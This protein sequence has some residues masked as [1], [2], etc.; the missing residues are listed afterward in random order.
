NIYPVPAR[1]SRRITMTIHEQLV[2]QKDR[3]YYK[4]AFNR[5]DTAQQ[6]DLKVSTSGCSAPRTGNGMLQGQNFRL[7]IDGILTLNKKSNKQDLN[8]AIAFSLEATSNVYCVQQQEGKTFF[9]ARVSHQVPVLLPIQ[10]KKLLVY[11]DASGSAAKRNLAREISFLKQYMQR[12]QTEILTLVTFAETL[13]SSRIFYP[14][15]NK[16]WMDLL[17]QLR[18]DGATRM[19]QLNLGNNEHDVVMVFS[20]G[21]HSFGAA[22]P[23]Q[24]YKPLYTISTSLHRDTIF[25]KNL[26]GNSGGRYIDLTKFSVPEAIVHSSS[27]VNKLMDIQS[28]AG[29]TLYEMSSEKNGFILR[30]TL[31]SDDTLTFIY[32]NRQKE[33]SRELMVLKKNGGCTARGIDRL[34]ML[35]QLQQR[36]LYWEDLLEFGL[37]QKIVTQNTAYIVLERIEDYIKYKITPPQEL[38]AACAEQ[39][40]ITQSPRSRRQMLRERDISTIMKDV[41]K[42]YNNQ[43]YLYDYTINGLTFYDPR[44]FQTNNTQREVTELNTEPAA[45]LLIGDVVNNSMNEVVVTGAFGTRRR[46]M[47]NSATGFYDHDYFMGS[48]DV[49]HILSGWVPGVSITGPNAAPGATANITIRG[50]G[51]L[52]GSSQPL[53]VLNGIPLD[54][55]INDMISVNDIESITVLKDAAA[56][57][58]YGSRGVN[59]VI[60]ITS[61]K[62]RPSSQY[63]YS[64]SYRLKDM[65]D[66][67]YLVRLKETGMNHKWAV[68]QEMRMYYGDHPI[69]YLEAAQ[70]FFEN[71]LTSQAVNIIMNAAEVS[72]GDHTVLRAIGYCMESW[73]LFAKASGIYR[74]LL[75]S[76]P[77]NLNNYHD[78]AWSLYQ[79]GKVEE[80]VRLLYTAIPLNLESNEHYFVDTKS[81]LL[82]DLNAM[83]AMHK[84]KYNFSFI[85]Q[86]LL[87]P[88][89]VELRIVITSNNSVSIYPE[90]REP[91]GS[92]CTGYYTKTQT[93]GYIGGDSH[94]GN[95]VDYNI[96]KA[97]K[98]KY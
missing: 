72:N 97:A 77:K 26:P 85:P 53:Y 88:M 39:G 93:G 42:V 63:N 10:T 13:A 92:I 90:I 94:Y 47:T 87:L 50:V 67:D 65:D 18:Y 96:K 34:N 46:T 51:S 8:Q 89:P 28:S 83:V 55:N 79:E 4:F 38:E 2:R 59:G 29:G 20:D 78:L 69:Y 66:E 54:G 91:G 70:H 61:K 62:Y 86:G 45:Q 74:Q 98:G 75:L 9:A 31:E 64:G 80:A 17:Y 76:Q 7:G 16:D 37:E 58:L 60:L 43:L 36:N 23:E 95:A 44:D 19:D 40:Y 68:Y 35:Q 49:Q 14:Q 5:Q 48:N 82:N 57:A 84:D 22:L 56:G 32:G 11:W 27:T 6:F 52:S 73:K 12:H 71:G 30:G 81:M 1:S 3:L 33:Y 21:F 25:L 24:A 15:K 41:L